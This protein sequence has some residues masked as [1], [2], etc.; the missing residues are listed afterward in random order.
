[1]N[2]QE[3]SIVDHGGTFSCIPTQ[4][5]ANI[6]VQESAKRLVARALDEGEVTLKS[7]DAIAGAD[8]VLREAVR[9]VLMALLQNQFECEVDD[10]WDVD[11]VWEILEAHGVVEGETPEGWQ[12]T[13]GDLGHIPVV[14]LE[15]LWGPSALL[16]ADWAGYLPQEVVELAE[17]N[18]SM[19]HGEQMWFRS[20]S[21]E[22]VTVILNNHG[23]MVSV[24]DGI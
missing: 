15:W 4:L 7:V 21:L 2:R 11:E 19:L 8:V 23:F 6:R 12:P 1:M 9:E 5:L 18:G 16:S 13:E 10:D 20:E 14:E 3:F 24:A 22:L 17:F